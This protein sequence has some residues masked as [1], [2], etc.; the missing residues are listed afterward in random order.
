MGRGEWWLPSATAGTVQSCAPGLHDMARAHLS[1]RRGGAEEKPEL[2]R[3]SD[4]VE[5]EDVEEKPEPQR[6]NA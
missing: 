5:W 4:G 2:R 3:S 1:P 6:W